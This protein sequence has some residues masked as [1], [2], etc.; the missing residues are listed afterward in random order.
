MTFSKNKKIN[1]I[2]RPKAIFWCLGLFIFLGLFSYGYLV[3]A[4]IINIV[5]RQEMNKEISILSS[6][7]VSL[8]SEYVKVKNNI[9][10]ESAK[11]LGFVSA[12]SQKFVTK[13]DSALGLSV[14]L[15]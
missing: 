8:E 1:N 14:N 11:S 9:T 12:S 13:T 10:V 2:E 3:K 6:K 5:D 7:V 4:S 15:R